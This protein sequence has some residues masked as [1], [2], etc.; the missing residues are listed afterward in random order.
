MASAIYH[1]PGCRLL[2]VNYSGGKVSEFI[3]EERSMMP[4][5]INYAKCVGCL[6][7]SAVMAIDYISMGRAD[8]ARD[9]LKYGLK[10]VE[11]SLKPKQDAVNP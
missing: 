2:V 6:E 5:P 10:E 9:I 7:A 4:E 1:L 11:R 3:R 8:K